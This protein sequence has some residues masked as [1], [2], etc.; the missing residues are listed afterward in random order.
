MVF[1]EVGTLS[2]F[3]TVVVVA[4]DAGQVL[5]LDGVDYTSQASNETMRVE[6]TGLLELGEG[7]WDMLTI[8]E[9]EYAFEPFSG[10]SAPVFDEGER[11]AEVLVESR[12]AWLQDALN[13]LLAVEVACRPGN[14]D[15]LFFTAEAFTAF[16]RPT[17]SDL[18][19]IM[20]GR[21]PVGMTSRRQTPVGIPFNMVTTAAEASSMLREVL[22]EGT[23]LVL[24][25]PPEISMLDPVTYLSDVQVSEEPGRQSFLGGHVIRWNMTGSQTRGPRIMAWTALWTYDDVADLYAGY[26]YTDLL[27]GRRYVD[28]QA[29][30]DE[31]QLA[32]F[33][34]TSGGGVGA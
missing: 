3:S 29:S 11:S 4:R 18:V 5:R 2:T 32:G 30:P 7:Y 12:T 33:S 16:E 24:R 1:V 27:D 22:I 14:R 6:G 28:W 34:T 31:A 20:G 10:D 19:Q 21:V 15:T 26:T 8:V 13:P 9:G 17:N 25:V 23:H